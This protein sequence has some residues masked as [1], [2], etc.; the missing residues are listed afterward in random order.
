MNL[1]REDRLRTG[2]C[3]SGPYSCYVSRRALYK[4]LLGLVIP[5]SS[6]ELFCTVS[7][8]EF[9]AVEWHLLEHGE[10]IFCEGGHSI[11]PTGHE[12]PFVFILEDVEEPCQS[13]RGA[14]EHSGIAAMGVLRQGL[15]H[16]LDVDH[17]LDPQ[18]DHR[19]TFRVHCSIFPNHPVGLEQVAVIG[20]VA[21]EVNAPC[22]FLAFETELD[23]ARRLPRSLQIRFDCL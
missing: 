23:A 21:A 11:I 17:P 19:V 14:R 15:H 18:R 7:L 20:D 13:P 5:H 4:G 9:I 3:V 10:L 1:L 6:E 12:Y 16:K 2:T 22:F 8:L